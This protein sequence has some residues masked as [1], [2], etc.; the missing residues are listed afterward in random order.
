MPAVKFQVRGKRNPSKISVRFM[1]DGQKDFRKNLPLTINPKYFNN[2]SG[3][4][5]NL[6]EFTDKNNINFK[7]CDFEIYLHKQ[8]IDHLKD[9]AFIDSNWLEKQINNFFEITDVTDNSLLIN[10]CDLFIEQLKNKSNDKTGEIGAT[11]A[12]ITKYNTIKKKLESFQIKS[13]NIYR[14]ID[15]NLNFRNQF[16]DYLLNDEKLGRNTAGR[17][18]RFLKTIMLDAKENSFKV[19]PELSKVKGFKVK[20]KHIFLTPEELEIII[21]TPMKT[22]Q[23][24]DARDLLY[25]GCFLGQRMSDLMKLSSSDFI[26]RGNTFVITRIQRKTKKNV[27]IPILPPVRKILKKR[28]GDFPKPF[29]SNDQSSMTIFNKLIKEVCKEAKLEEIVEGSKIDENT[30]RKITGMFPKYELVTSHICRRS[31][32]TNLY[33][34]VPTPYIISVTGHSTEKAFLDYISKP[35]LD[36]VEEM[37]A[38]FNKIKF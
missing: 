15:V 23:L 22:K 21:N 33:G 14:L 36:M 27:A 1:M 24:E 20:T 29:S 10:Y 16:L 31:F 8:Y 13:K 11:K 28:G 9:I 38:Y 37:T 12:T 5:R 25:M 4:V 2:K 7:L 32:A 18:L 17:Y 6:A 34:K 3:K 19:S 35:Q 26:Q 30:N